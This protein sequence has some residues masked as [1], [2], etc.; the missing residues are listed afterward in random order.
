MCLHSKATGVHQKGQLS[1]GPS[2]APLDG[3]S[4][5]LCDGNSW[6]VSTPDVSG[7][8]NCNDDC[9]CEKAW[10]SPTFLNYDA[11]TRAWVW[12]GDRWVQLGK[13]IVHEDLCCFLCTFENSVELSNAGHKVVFENS[14]H[15]PPGT[16]GSAGCA[17]V[18][19]CATGTV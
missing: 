6:V 14:G 4:H 13:A 9:F 3:Q 2:V 17:T 10:T 11:D 18:P 12:M 16:P 15:E 1:L 8:G 19:G 7:S 5:C